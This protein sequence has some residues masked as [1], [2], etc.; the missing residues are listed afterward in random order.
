MLWIQVDTYKLEYTTVIEM[1]SNIQRKDNAGRIISGTKQ[2]Y[3]YVH[4]IRT[5]YTSI[6]ILLKTQLYF[7]NGGATGTRNCIEKL[8]EVIKKSDQSKLF[9]RFVTCKMNSSTPLTCPETMSRFQS[10]RR[11]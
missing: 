1:R 5:K 8:N 4:K 2:M 11:S 10:C 9:L 6:L 3:L 7:P